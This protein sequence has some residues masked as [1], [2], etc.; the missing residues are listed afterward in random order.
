MLLAFVAVSG[1]ARSTEQRLEL[2]MNR[3]GVQ[4]TQVFPLEGTVTID[5]QAPDFGRANK[6]LLVILFDPKQP[7][8][9]AAERPHVIVKKNGQFTFSTYLAQDGVEPGHYVVTFAAFRRKGAGTFIGPDQLN[10]LYNDPDL[11]GAKAEF[12]M[13]HGSPGKKD[14]SFNLEIAGKEPA[15]PGPRTVTTLNS[16]G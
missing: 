5:G 3:A 15:K 2:A 10:N 4:K 6:H 9:P 7:D 13:E 16:R 12:N 8:V 1:C 11:N 14:Y